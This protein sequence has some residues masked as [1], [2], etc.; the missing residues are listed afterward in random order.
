M[1]IQTPN[2]Q[3]LLRPIE[4]GLNRLAD[5]ASFR[6]DYAGPTR[7]VPSLPLSKF[8]RKIKVAWLIGTALGVACLAASRGQP[9]VLLEALLLIAVSYGIYAKSRICAVT[10]FIGSV[11]TLIQFLLIFFRGQELVLAYVISLVVEIASCYIFFQGLNG[12]FAY[13]TANKISSRGLLS[14]P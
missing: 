7:P 2:L 11:G 1:R 6:H 3:G 5:I 4:R 13:H 14:H 9:L 12:V 10:L 8:K